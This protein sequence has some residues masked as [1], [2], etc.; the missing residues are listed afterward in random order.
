MFDKL[1]YVCRCSFEVEEKVD[2]VILILIIFWCEIVVDKY[3]WKRNL[4]DE[5]KR[6]IFGCYLESI[7]EV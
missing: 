1:N 7:L 5:L 3:E 4:V 2:V 6:V